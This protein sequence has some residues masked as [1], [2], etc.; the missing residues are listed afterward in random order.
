[1]PR[2]VIAISVACCRRPVALSSSRVSPES[3]THPRATMGR[4]NALTPHAATRS[5]MTAGEVRMNGGQI[6][7]ITFGPGDAGS[8]A[9][10]ADRVFVSGGGSAFLAGMFSRTEQGSTGAGGAVAVT[11]GELEVRDGGL[12]ASDSVGAK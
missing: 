9:V 10:D 2:S 7:A 3:G 1:M 8:V 4:T 6:R 11:A 5:G 12:I